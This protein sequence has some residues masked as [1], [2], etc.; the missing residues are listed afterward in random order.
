[1]TLIIS[2]FVDDQCDEFYDIETERKVTQ[3]KKF[4]R[5]FSLHTI[6]LWKYMASVIQLKVRSVW[7]MYSKPYNN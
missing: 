6:I 2:N 7:F 4:P 3:D 1:M 5:I